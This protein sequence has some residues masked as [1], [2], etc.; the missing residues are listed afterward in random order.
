MGGM[1]EWWQRLRGR[2]YGVPAPAPKSATK[3]PPPVEGLGLADEPQSRKPGHIGAAGFNPYSSD[4]G[5]E[6]PHSWERVDHD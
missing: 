5:Y 6:K 3:K 1:R 4:A 2:A